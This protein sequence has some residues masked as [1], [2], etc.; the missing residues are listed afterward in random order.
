LQID[1]SATAYCSLANHSIFANHQDLLNTT[2]APLFSLAGITL[3]EFMGS[4]G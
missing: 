4:N 3:L 2:F 1:P